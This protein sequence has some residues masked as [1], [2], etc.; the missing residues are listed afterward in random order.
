MEN[1]VEF[2][3]IEYSYPDGT[4][5]INGI[6]LEIKKGEIL[7]LMGE[8]GS[9]KSTIY[10][11]LTGIIKPLKG[12]IFVKGSKLE[13][14]KKGLYNLRKNV[15]I[16]FQQSDDQLFSADVRQ[17]ISFGLV[18]LGLDEIKVKEKVDEIIDV[19]NMK[20][21]EKKPVQFLSGGQK[22][23]V[24]V[25]DVVVMEPEIILFDEPYAGMDPKNA[26]ILDEII[27]KLADKGKTLII[28]THD[29]DKALEMADRI[30]IMKNG[31]ILEDGI[32][33]KVFS[34]TEVL[35]KSNLE[36]PKLIQVLDILKEMKIIEE[37]F[38]EIP[39]NISQLK[40]I[41]ANKE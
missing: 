15:G 11:L 14:N 30:V 6:D 9:G 12:N 3:N 5:A 19:F 38:D 16:I 24:A 18:N 4:K 8:N 29:C 34:K 25:S 20:S 28:S 41:I 35:R 22:K 2:N 37:N 27:K 17:D 26:N 7:A 1:I 39:C 33:G 36:K 40:D 23:R 10:K 13:Y 31:K 21:F 32:P